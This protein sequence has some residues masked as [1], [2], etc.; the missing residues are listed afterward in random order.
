MAAGLLT[1]SAVRCAAKAALKY[2]VGQFVLISTDKAVRPT[3]VMG[4]SKRVAELVVMLARESKSTVFSIHS[5]CF[6]LIGVS[7]STVQVANRA[8]WSGHSY[9]P[10]HNTIL[11][12]YS[13]SG[14]VGSPGGR[15]G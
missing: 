14:G 8:G 13:R 10:R 1:I 11:H 4:A 5:K 12:D 3:N 2:N 6:G 7:C 15:N 9:A